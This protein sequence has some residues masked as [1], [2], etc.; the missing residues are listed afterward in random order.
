MPRGR[1]RKPYWIGFISGGILMA[2]LASGLA[3]AATATLY[4]HDVATV[5]GV[6]ITESQLMWYML[7]SDGQKTAGDLISTAILANQA[8]AY[9]V[10]VDPAKVDGILKDM[11]GDKLADVA[12]GVNIDEVKLAINREL[13]ARDVYDAQFKKFAADPKY[14]VT[15][16]EVIDAYVRN[17]DKMTIPE[18]VQLSIINTKDL[19]NADAALADI[20]AGKSFADTA[21]KYSED[22]VTRKNGGKFEKAL[23]K[24]FFRG[25]LKKL[26]D[27]AFKLNIGDHSDVITAGD[28]YFII[29]LDAKLP[30]KE[31]SLD[32]ARADIRDELEQRKIGPVM[33]DWL[34]SLG[35]KAQVKVTYPIL[36]GFNEADLTNIDL[37]K[38]PDSKPS[39]PGPA[40]KTP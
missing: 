33:G 15:D 9:N 3:W 19:K 16:D 35:A 36:A 5:D 20:K 7:S 26:E 13:A 37:S 39:T 30:S 22:E 4:A 25:P 1:E 2:V 27:I 32:E 40:P 14:A 21:M 24:G 10:T 38:G 34:Q 6:T 18:A 17:A 11:Y 23:P 8:K 31:I 28:E 29:Q 12:R